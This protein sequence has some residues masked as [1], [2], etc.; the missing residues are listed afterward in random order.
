MTE[1]VRRP[2]WLHQ[3]AEYV[4]GAALVGSG[5][6]SPSPAIPAAL[7]GLVVLN[8]ACADA[9]LG[10]FRAVGRRVHRIL[11]FALVVLGVVATALPGLDLGTRIVQGCCVIV[12]VTVVANTNYASAP[13][14]SS[15][16]S[17]NRSGGSRA[18]ELGRTAGRTA[19]TVAA[20]LRKK[21]GS[22]SAGDQDRT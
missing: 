12:F 21:W 22:R 2:F 7:G 6:Q 17:T 14:R 13:E 10:A 4:V 5:L 18:D 20:Q 3:V 19:G 1:R 8:A 9:P 11:D 15:A 16:A